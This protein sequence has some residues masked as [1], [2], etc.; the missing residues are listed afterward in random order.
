MNQFCFQL[1]LYLL[2]LAVLA[3]VRPGQS[4]DA[5]YYVIPADQPPDC[6]GYPC[7]LLDE[8]MGQPERYFSKDKVN[9]TMYFAPGVYTTKYENTVIRDLHTF[10]MAGKGRAD[11]IV[12]CFSVVFNDVSNLRIESL[13]LSV[14]GGCT[15]S[16]MALVR[17]GVVII[18]SVVGGVGKIATER[19]K[20]TS[21]NNTTDSNTE[22]TIVPLNHEIGVSGQLCSMFITAYSNITVTNG[23]TF[24]N[25]INTPITTYESVVTLSGNITF[26]NNT[27]TKG[28]AIALYSST[29]NIARNTS[30]DFFNNS[31]R[32]VG[33]AIYV[34]MTTNPYD[35]QCFYQLLNYDNSS[36]EYSLRFEKNKA[37]KGGDHIYGANMQSICS[38]AYYKFSPTSGW[39]GEMISSYEAVKYYF[40][41]VT[42]SISSVSSDPLGICLCD[43]SGLP[44]CANSISDIYQDC[45]MSPGQTFSL[46]VAII[47]GSFGTTTGTV[48]ADFLPLNS[49][50]SHYVPSLEPIYQYAQWITNYKECFELE[51]T[52]YSHN[53]TEPI[54]LYLTS[55]SESQP[56]VRERLG[57]RDKLKSDIAAYKSRGVIYESLLTTPIFLNITLL[58]CPRGFSLSGEP[59]RCNCYVLL[60]LRQYD[61]NCS[62]NGTISWSGLLWIGTEDDSTL[63]V[64]YSCPVDYC[65][66]GFK[67]V[68]FENNDTSDMCAFN[69]AGRLCGGCRSGYSLAIGSSHCIHCHKNYN[70]ALFIFFAAAGLLLVL[71]ISALNL[72]VTQGTINGITFYANI[73][74]SYQNI[75]LP[76]RDKNYLFRFLRCFMAWLNLDFGIQTCFIKGLN[77]F[78]KTWLQYLFPLYIWTIAGL[79][80]VG[81]KYS[82]KLTKLFGNRAVSVLATL[83]LLS[84][85]K[86]LKVIIDSLGFTPIKVFDNNTN[87]TLT[88]WSLYGNY[89]YGHFPHILLVITALFVFLFMCLP[90]T[91]G[92][93]LMPWLRRISGFKLLRWIPRLNPVFDAYFAPL[94]DKHHYWFGVLLIVRGVLLVIFTTTCTIYPKINYFLL[95]MTSALL[96]CYANYHRVYKNRAV[97]LTENLFLILLVFVGGSGILD[98]NARHMVAYLSITVGL[99][100]LAG[101][102]IIRNIIYRFCFKKKEI[103][104]EHVASE[105]TPKVQLLPE[106]SYNSRFRDSI[107][108]ETEPLIKDSY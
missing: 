69:H 40:T 15:V 13:T 72:T 82:S 22:C 90:F 70:L 55:T 62:V 48:Y 85:T 74:W 32:E 64:S 3:L 93:F 14:A 2:L 77:A 54:I 107:L 27:G 91:F 12:V 76:Q 30:V 56:T 106:I 60:Q 88:V 5:I 23:T 49:S 67:T 7:M 34:A 11:D 19:S 24:A 94:K 104:M 105:E 42:D 1:F 98:D 47:G 10:E 37:G 92:L 71:F 73:F 84:Y 101:I 21:F 68:N 4:T 80:I 35:T 99:L 102:I 96:L 78:W 65:K 103:D 28:G 8:Y 45:S 6:L 86:L 25:L 50:N 41:F 89:T 61:I 17:V 58:P 46:S 100:A 63:D 33:G 66:Q 97:Q 16:K 59:P 51:Y 57:R 26:V 75:L 52:I 87:Y 18:K 9:V 38:V 29:L 83:F 95:L 53:T 108:D 79:I 39:I 43:A 44:R 31:A 36:K 20:V 81:A